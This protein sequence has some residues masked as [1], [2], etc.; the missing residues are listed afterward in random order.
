[1]RRLRLG[2]V[3]M[4]TAAI[5]A[6]GCSNGGGEDTSGAGNAP[7]AAASDRLNL[8]GVCPDTVVVQTDW[9]PESE[10]GVWYHLVGPNPRVD[11]NKK[12]VSGPLVAEGRDTGVRIE[13][14]SGGPATGFELVS[15]QM[16]KDRDI[17]V[18]QVNTDEAVRFS[19]KQPTL[20]V[21]AP[22]EISPFMIMWD[23][24]TYPQFN[25]IADIGKTDTKVLFFEGDTYMAYLTGT[26]VLKK[27]QVDGSYDGKPGN[28]VAADGKIAQAGFATSE[29]YIYEHEVRQWA[30]P[31]K[32]A[33]VSEAGYPFYPQALSIR[34]ADK[35]KLAPCLK[36]LV[37]IV[38][39]A[40]VDFLANPD[41]TNAFIIDT[42]KKYNTFWTYSTG[43]AGYAIK[44]MRL[45]FVNNGTD[46]TL[47][48]FE[49]GRIQRLIDIVTPILVGQ[50]QQT[51][52]GL[53]PQ[54]LYTNDFIDPSI[55]VVAS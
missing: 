51:K 41:K 23:P 49:V 29:P 18:G 8:K 50:R 7:A 33:L 37:P 54:D 27:E 39:R 14:R 25:T 44:E 55:G 36:K 45:N 53:R 34:A 5:V 46:Q 42:V 32:Y 12:L 1:V 52:E 40:Q 30:K 26:G 38:Q 16:Y 21:A 22:M 31:V 24:A 13:V 15:A 6:A 48:N 9:F 28:F 43:L 35:A 17:T 2:L 10:Y 47:G 11:T 4:A 20:A 3:V 19:A